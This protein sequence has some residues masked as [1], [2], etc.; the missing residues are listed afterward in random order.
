MF[1]I[2][3]NLV[4]TTE[5]IKF[6]SVPNA[7]FI[8]TFSG[9]LNHFNK[10]LIKQEWQD[11]DR[12]FSGIDLLKLVKHLILFLHQQGLLTIKNKS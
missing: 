3:I 2:L 7:D 12:F 6:D 1:L 9:G 5:K 10:K 8:V 11:P 4:E